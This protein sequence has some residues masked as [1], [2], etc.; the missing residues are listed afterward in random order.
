MFQLCQQVDA[1]GLPQGEWGLRLKQALPESQLRM[2]WLALCLATSTW[3]WEVSEA[4]RDLLPM[5]VCSADFVETKIL[6]AS[7]PAPCQP[8]AVPRAARSASLFL[9]TLLVNFLHLGSSP[10]LQGPR[11]EC[12]EAQAARLCTTPLQL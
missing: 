3:A 1:R 4:P 12:Y 7:H 8:N 11:A 5:P 10:K 9:L 2:G 6:Q